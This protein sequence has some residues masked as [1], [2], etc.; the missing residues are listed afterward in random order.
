ME[1]GAGARTVA[2]SRWCVRIRGSGCSRSSRVQRANS[3]ISYRLPKGEPERGA[4]AVQV[5]SDGLA[6]LEA[7]HRAGVPVWMRQLPVWQPARPGR[8]PLALSPVMTAA[9]SPSR[10]SRPTKTRSATASAQTRAA[11]RTAS[12]G[13]L[14]WSRCTRRGRPGR[15]TAAAAPQHHAS[16]VL[17][18]FR[19]RAV[20]PR[21]AG[22][23]QVDHVQHPAPHRGG[24]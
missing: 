3:S 24:R 16:A 23:Q 11:V 6:L 18:H 5:G 1:R 10:S 19:R 7:V 2:P 4:S 14:L 13:G 21:R 22:D 15:S 17:G 20:Q 12:R 8:P 9:C